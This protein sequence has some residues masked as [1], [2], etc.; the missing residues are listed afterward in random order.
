[1]G[2]FSL[3]IRDNGTTFKPNGSNGIGRGISNIRSRAGI[4][5]ANISWQEPADG[6]N[7]FTLEI[8]GTNGV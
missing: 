7:V 6:G 4:I 2:D 8:A 3:S 1:M 5:N